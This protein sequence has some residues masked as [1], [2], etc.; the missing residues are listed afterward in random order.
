MDHNKIVIRFVLAAAIFFYIVCWL[1]DQPTKVWW[2]IGV[3][4]P[5]LSLF[6]TIP[7]TLIFKVKEEDS[8]FTWGCIYV[9][10][11]ILYVAAMSFVSGSFLLQLPYL[12]ACVSFIAYFALEF[13]TK[14]NKEGES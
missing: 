3:A 11:T 2:Y 1:V 14:I 9:V 6:V 7:I 8:Y 13:K 4:I 10:S 5:W 12:S